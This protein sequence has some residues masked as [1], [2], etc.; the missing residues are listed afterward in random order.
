VIG[1]GAF[2]IFLGV[3]A[4]AVAQVAW[5]IT[6]LV[7]TGAERRHVVMFASE[8]SFFM[9]LLLLGVWLMYR[10]LAEQV[11]LREMRATFLSSVTHELKSP[12][13]AIRLFLE[14]LEQGR[15]D[16]E[17]RRDLVRKM[18]LDTER[19]E[20]LVNDLLRAG[21]IEAGALSADEGEARLDA[22]VEGAAERAR[23]RCGPGDEVRVEGPG[24]V[25]VP[26]DEELLRSA[27]ENLLD[28]AV[29]YSPG[30]Q[31]VEVDV[32]RDEDEVV[33]AVRDHGL[34]IPA[35][36]QAA[37]FTKFHRGAEARTRGIR[38]TGLGLAMVDHIVRAHHGRVD[39]ESQPGRG[40]TF[41]IRLPVE[42]PSV[43]GVR[44]SVRPSVRGV[45]L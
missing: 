18:L 42:E 17:K 33:V 15:A 11:R 1:R 25:L 20:R 36:E 29:K 10:T 30:A 21:R 16:E 24:P 31:A 12:L 34:G 37:L 35:D 40:S 6:F 14:T 13:A 9:V 3:C 28:N 19:L 39:V 5:W 27:V 32:R 22:V 26:G 41:R 38:G 4:L 8:G 45:R 23:L 44:S 7:R 2:A 43:R